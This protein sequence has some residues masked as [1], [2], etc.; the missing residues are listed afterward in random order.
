MG[1]GVSADGIILSG[2]ATDGAFLLVSRRLVSGT[3]EGLTDAGARQISIKTHS[4]ARAPCGARRQ[5][6]SVRGLRHAGAIP[7]WRPER[8]FARTKRRRPVRR[9][10]YGPARAAGEIRQ[11]RGCGAR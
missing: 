3:P 5:D 7:G 11:G 6:G 1:P 2:T 10:P 8:A 9:L 4:P